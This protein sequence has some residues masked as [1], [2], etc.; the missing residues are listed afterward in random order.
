MSAVLAVLLFWT[1]SA[2]SLREG[3]GKSVA[4]VYCQVCHSLDYIDMNAGILN[5][6]GWE[7][8]VN[9]MIIDYGAPVPPADVAV[10][11]KYLSTNY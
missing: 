10:L 4:M 11:V 6:K 7:T 5:E 3:A 8:E 9:K 1:S 2:T